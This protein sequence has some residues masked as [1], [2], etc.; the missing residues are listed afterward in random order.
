LAELKFR[1]SARDQPSTPPKCTLSFS[2]WRSEA[3][4]CARSESRESSIHREI[5]PCAIEAWQR[6]LRLAKALGS[7]F[8]SAPRPRQIR[9]VPRRSF[10]RCASQRTKAKSAEGFTNRFIFGPLGG[11]LRAFAAN[12]MTSKLKR[13]EMHSTKTNPRVIFKLFG[14]APMQATLLHRNRGG[15][16]IQGGKLAEFLGGCDCSGVEVDV[17]FVSANR[18]EWYKTASANA[19]GAEPSR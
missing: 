1:T 4:G 5:P 9:C 18:V 12:A 11:T 19:R 16:W 6:Q 3:L 15:F 2:G 13:S 10:L 17:C 7:V 8:T 14:Q